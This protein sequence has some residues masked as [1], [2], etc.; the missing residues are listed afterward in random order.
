MADPAISV[1][2]AT[3]NGATLVGQTIDCVLA[4]SFADFELVI[5]DDCSTDTTPAVVRAY[6]DPRIRVF[7]TPHNLGPVG[8]RNQALPELRG[9][10]IA[11]MDQDDLCLPARFAAQLAYLDAHPDTVLVGTATRLLREGRQVPD[12]YPAKTTPDLLWWLLHIVNPLVWSSVMF[13]TDAARQLTP[14][15]RNEVLFAEDYDLYHRLAKFGKIARLDEALTIYRWHAQGASR[16]HEIKMSDSAAK[17]LA[18]AYKPWFG[19]AGQAYAELLVTHVAA[20]RPV[21]DK[22][23]LNRVA[24]LFVSIERAFVATYSPDADSRALI[25][26]EMSR[27]WWAVARTAI[28]AGTLSQ[29]VVLDNRPD[30]AVPAGLTAKELFKSALLGGLRARQKS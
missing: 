21:A 22:S 13:R 12:R 26:A 2:M 24:A 7:S 1:L 14:F 16:L 9:R 17:V 30:F 3:Y 6:T 20:G 19:P 28:R 15:A 10:Y 8:A 25:N 18:A 29:A 11:A 5:I 4:Q 27:L 23:T